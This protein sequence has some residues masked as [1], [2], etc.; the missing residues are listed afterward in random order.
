MKKVILIA[1]FII[2][3]AFFAF[4]DDK[5]PPTHGDDI[6][7]KTLAAAKRG[8][9]YLAQKQNPDGSWNCKIGYKLSEEYIGEDGEDVGIT[10]L[11]GMAFLASGE[12]PG[13]GKYGKVIDGA[14]GF[15]LDCVREEDG[16]IT[17]NGT[18]MY[19]HA[20]ATM[21]LAEIYG[22][23]PKE[24][25]KEKLKRAVNA[26]VCSQNK[27]GGWRYQPI[28]A[29]ADLSVTVSTLQAVRAARN[30]GISVPKD[31]IERATQYVKKCAAFQT[32]NGSFLGFAYQPG[33]I[34]QTRFT[35]P[36]TACGIVSLCSAG[37]YGS[38]AVED[39]VKDLERRMAGKIVPGEMMMP[40]PRWGDYHY[41]YG[42]YY[43]VQAMYQ[44]GGQYWDNYFPSLRDEIVRN[45]LPDGSWQ[46]EIGKNYA[47][48]MA[49]LILQIP[50]EYLPI[51][52]K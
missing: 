52:Q 1:M 17:K 12:V 36:L 29:D 13:R 39:G 2:S 28:P 15:V 48:A 6:D 42:H 3:L 22:M 33:E 32:Q 21:F 43:G 19:S 41:F 45:Q 40:M 23:A 37:E 26:I 27:E 31:T 38:K 51:F 7:A 20:F 35:F 34:Y 47:T 16:Y 30:V 50:L 24:E 14:L 44:A 18:R 4:T 8:L 9:Q 11:A 5:K 46:D 49:C 10:A 25:I